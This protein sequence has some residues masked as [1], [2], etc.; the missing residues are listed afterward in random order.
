[1]LTDNEIDKID[2]KVIDGLHRSMSPLLLL[3]DAQI[4]FGVS[5]Q[6]GTLIDPTK[7]KVF[8]TVIRNEEIR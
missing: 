1:M 8:P 5:K 7:S 2:E 3:K 6:D 4:S